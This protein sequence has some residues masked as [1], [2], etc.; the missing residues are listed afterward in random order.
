MAATSLYFPFRSSLRSLDLSLHSV[1]GKLNAIYPSKTIKHSHDTVEPDNEP[2]TNKM[3]IC[4]DIA[5]GIIMSKQSSHNLNDYSIE[6]EVPRILFVPA[7]ISFS[8]PKLSNLILDSS[9]RALI[10]FS[11]PFT[12]KLK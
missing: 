9:T 10:R 7:P 3:H 12:S 1:V 2:L 11:P 6:Y 8:D 5:L 4:C